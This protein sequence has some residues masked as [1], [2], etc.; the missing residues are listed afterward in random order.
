VVVCWQYAPLHGPSESGWNALVAENPFGSAML[1]EW[2]N[3]CRLA[4]VVDP[5]PVRD[6]G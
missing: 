6:G 4:N 3:C 2:V 5:R 1:V